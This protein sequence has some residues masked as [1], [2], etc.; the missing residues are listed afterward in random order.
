MHKMYVFASSETKM[1]D[2]EKSVWPIVRESFW[3]DW[4]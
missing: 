2:K 1:K 4:K 3:S